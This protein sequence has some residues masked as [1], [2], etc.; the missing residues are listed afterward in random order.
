MADFKVTDMPALTIEAQSLLTSIEH[1]YHSILSGHCHG[2]T[3]SDPDGALDKIRTFATVFYDFFY[4][5]YSKFPDHS[6]HWRFASE[7]KTIERIAAQIEKF[8]ATRD[9]VN[10]S[11]VHT[12]KLT[13][14]NH[15]KAT[16]AAR[17]IKPVLDSPKVPAIGFNDSP[18]L[19]MAKSIQFSSPVAS[20]RKAFVQPLL[21]AKGWSIAEWAEKA[22]VSRHTAKSYLEGNRKTYHSSMKDL[23]KALGVTFQ[24]LPK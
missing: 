15:A 24:E 10:A 1:K 2:Y 3:L 22:K 16:A 14:T 5:F 4:S 18:S 8:T 13:I 21:D 6:E 9:W 19:R 17:L 23:A 12:I 11:V 20:K 7:V